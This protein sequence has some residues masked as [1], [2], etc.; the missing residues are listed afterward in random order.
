MPS[1]I[2]LFRCC[3]W[4]HILCMEPEKVSIIPYSIGFDFFVIVHMNNLYLWLVHVQ[5]Y[6]I[7]NNYFC[8]PF[9][10]VIIE[11]AS[12][13]CIIGRKRSIHQIPQ[14]LRRINLWEKN[15]QKINFW[16]CNCFS[17]FE[18]SHWQHVLIISQYSVH[19]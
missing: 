17:T 12:N 3:L 10:M 4:L 9:K 5:F 8:I 16:L 6:I 7:I 1:C 11:L 2:F 14:N 18:F 15:N 19:Q 13:H